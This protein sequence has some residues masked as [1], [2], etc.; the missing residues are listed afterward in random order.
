MPEDPHFCLELLVAVLL[1][2]SKPL[3]CHK[4][5]R[6]H[7]GSVCRAKAAVTNAVASVEIPSGANDG[8]IC[9]VGSNINICENLDF[10]ARK[11]AL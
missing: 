2:N 7:L 1:P 4:N 11:G 3:Y 9:Q 10:F 5:S 8:L 6:C